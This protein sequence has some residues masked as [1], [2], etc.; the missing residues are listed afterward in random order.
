LRGVSLIASQQDNSSAEQPTTTLENVGGGRLL[1]ASVQAELSVQRTIPLEKSNV[2]NC[3][4]ARA[5]LNATDNSIVQ[6]GKESV[7]IKPDA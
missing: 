2:A 3:L 6:Y 4:R 7:A 5:S 1:T